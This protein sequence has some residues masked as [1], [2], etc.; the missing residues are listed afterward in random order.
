MKEL[1]AQFRVALIV[2]LSLAVLVCGL[3]PAIVWILAQ[4]IFPANANGSLI[5]QEG[6]PVGS[7]LIGQR[8]IGPG[9]FHPRPSAAGNGYDAGSSGGSNLGPISR[10]LVDAVKKRVHDYRTENGLPPDVLIPVDAVTTSASGLDPHI[11]VKNAYL[12]APRIALVRGMSENVVIREIG[13][14]IEGRDLGILGERRVNVLKLNMT[15][16]DIMKKN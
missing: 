3:Y 12:Q 13:K 11:S 8:F 2:V 14:H 4:G 6:K 15:L 16:D 1:F 7:V 9:Y 5:M 10:K